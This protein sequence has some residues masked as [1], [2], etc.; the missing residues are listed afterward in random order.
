[1]AAT[2]VLLFLS[3]FML[4]LLQCENSN[5]PLKRVIYSLE[6]LIGF[7][8]ENYRDL[9]L[10]G[11]F[12]LRALEGHLQ[13][14]LAE[15]QNGSHTH[16]SS[17]ILSRLRTMAS[18]ST[19]IS[20]QAI[21]FVRKDDEGYY[22]SM[23][24][25]IGQPWNILHKHRKLDQ[26]LRWTPK[27]Y[28]STKQ[29]KI[30]EATSDKCMAELT[31]SNRSD[32][33]TCYIGKECLDTMTMKGLTEYGI[34]HQ[35]LWTMLAEKTNCLQELNSLLGSSKGTSTSAMQQEFCTNNF[36]E[37][38]AVVHVYMKGK[39][40]QDYQDLFLEQ[41]FVC[42]SLGFYEFLKKEYLDQVLSWQFPSGCFGD[43]KGNVATSSSE[44]RKKPEMQNMDGPLDMLPQNI[45]YGQQQ[46]QQLQQQNSKNIQSLQNNNM[47][48]LPHNRG[49]NIQSSNIL[50]S[51]FDQRVDTNSVYSKNLNNQNSN[52]VNRLAANFNN[53]IPGLNNG[54][55]NLQAP[56][57]QQNYNPN[58]ANNL[59]API[60]QQN[61]NPNGVNNLQAPV[62]Q[63][64]NNPDGVHLNTLAPFL[65]QNIVNINNNNDVNN[66]M[67][68]R[69]QNSVFP[70]PPSDT[71]NLKNSKL[72]QGLQPMGANVIKLNDNIKPNVIGQG[73]QRQLMS[74]NENTAYVGRKLLAEKEM[75]DGCMAHT[76]AVATGALVMYLRY[77]IDPGPLDLYSSHHI[78]QE[79]SRSLLGQGL[80]QSPVIGGDSRK[81]KQEGLIPVKDPSINL[82][83]DPAEDGL[84]P[85][86]VVEDDEEEDE[87]ED[88]YE[89]GEEDAEE[90]DD[91][92]D[93]NN[94]AKN[95][96]E[97]YPD[98]DN[99]ADS[100]KHPE[101]KVVHFG[102]RPKEIE[103]KKNLYEGG[104]GDYKENGK[105]N[106]PEDADYTYYEEDNHAK[107]S[108]K[109]VVNANPIENNN[110]DNNDIDNNNNNI[111]IESDKDARV[112]LIN[113]NI[114]S[115]IVKEPV[116]PTPPSMKTV[117]VFFSVCSM[118]I[119]FFM[120][121]FIKK[122][123]I[124][125]RY[126]PRDFLRL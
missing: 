121:R 102:L 35:I 97:F 50:K 59:Q 77:L 43:P 58:G 112:N 18:V 36:F 48:T 24:Y 19:L 78:L 115:E 114:D 44:I 5:S 57:G 119:L 105:K 81:V 90:D 40:K 71:N 23:S 122:R 117:F 120:F 110:I 118:V 22:N 82:N 34:T 116:T 54:A 94:D 111:D 8:R 29:F 27:I 124:H 21:E 65:Q 101:K 68:R 107:N 17:D 4:P 60:G 123:R 46:Q 53:P 95:D 42:P 11:L 13:L 100:K 73:Q 6:T 75:K 28:K 83:P 14:I 72:Y 38:A 113:P 39:I 108:P 45:N 69:G 51:Q 87:E 10:D 99:T 84:N 1:M 64:N 88:E 49:Q 66:P 16:L 103:I 25:V 37:M 52:L 7:Y 2:K 33:K 106:N 70:L 63:Q 12:G 61:Y 86:E 41:Q 20:N 56:V 76:T 74:A 67:Q 109:K 96:D 30:D 79:T 31:G 125:I 93:Y 92:P 98:G 9:N 62:G 26:A 126:H 55:N 104:E 89:D 47:D 80:D 85:N 3:L 32:K 15:H 91:D